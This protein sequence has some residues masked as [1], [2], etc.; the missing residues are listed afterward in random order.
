MVQFLS[1]LWTKVHVVLR[2]YRRPLVVYTLPI[3][4][5]VYCSKDIG[6]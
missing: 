3:V 4:Y 5:I 1:R 2:Q 6:H